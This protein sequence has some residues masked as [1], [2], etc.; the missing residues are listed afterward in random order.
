MIPPLQPLAHRGDDAYGD[1]EVCI[2]GIWY[3]VED[4]VKIADFLQAGR[5]PFFSAELREA[6]RAEL[7]GL[8]QF[9]LSPVD[10]HIRH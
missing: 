6:S 1:H 7:D 5:D 2:D 3:S 4:L 10:D 8:T 9:W